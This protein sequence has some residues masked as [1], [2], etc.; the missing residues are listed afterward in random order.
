MT[1]KFNVMKD[2]KVDGTNTNIQTKTDGRPRQT[3]V[4]TDSVYI[5]RHK[6]TKQKK[7]QIPHFTVL[8]SIMV[9]SMICLQFDDC[10]ISCLHLP[11]LPNI[12]F[13]KCVVVFA[14]KTEVLIE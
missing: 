12:F 4:A 8:L 5:G 3:D 7:T 10:L 13:P 14:R 11:N 1:V 6:I 9:V 2:Y